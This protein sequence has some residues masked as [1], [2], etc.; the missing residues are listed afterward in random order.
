MYVIILFKLQAV[1]FVG[2]VH[3]GC[4]YYWCFELLVAVTIQRK[5]VH[6]ML[7]WLESR[8]LFQKQGYHRNYLE[9]KR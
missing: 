6:T 8:L 1:I 5:S 7:F 9:I 4:F 2:V 3:F